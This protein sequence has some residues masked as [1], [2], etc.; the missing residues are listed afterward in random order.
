MR[1]L[2]GE[3]GVG[4]M[5]LYTYVPGKAE[6]LDLMLDRVYLDMPRTAARGGWR[7]R[8]RAVAHDNRALYEAHPWAA[9]V[10]STRPPLG[11]GLIGKYDRELSALEATGLGDVELDAALTFLLDFVRSSAIAAHEAA[12]A[13]SA[14]GMTDEQWWEANAP[15]LARALDPEAYPTAARV[16]SAAGAAHGGAYSPDH[17]WKFGLERVLDGLAALIE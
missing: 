6:L 3:L 5:A 7:K 13:R 8:L 14:S 17:A 1:R 10:S 15:L 2:A 12:A 9:T 4:A 16:G 11:P